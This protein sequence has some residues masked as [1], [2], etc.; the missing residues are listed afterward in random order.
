[1]KCINIRVLVFVISLAMSLA[2]SFDELED[3]SNYLKETSLLDQPLKKFPSDDDD[4]S[5]ISDHAWEES[6]RFEGDLILNER[7]RQLIV[8][9]IAEGLSRNGLKDSTKRWPNNEVIVYIQREHFTSDQV[10]A[11]VSGM[12][13]LSQ[14][15]CVKF[16]PYKKGDRD[17]VVVQGSRRGCFSQVGYQGGYQVLNLSGRHPVGR[18]CFRHGTV[19][20]EFLH[21][22]GFYHMQSSPDRDDYIDVIWENIVQPAR[23]NFRKYNLFSVSDFGVGYDYDSV[24]HYSRKAFSSNGGDTLVPKKS[25]AEIGQRI[26]LSE[27]DSAKLNKMYCD[28][29]SNNFEAADD[30]SHAVI[31]K[32]KTPKNKPFD[33]HGIG[34]H[35]GKTV[36]FKLPAADNYR[37]PEKPSNALFDYF[38]KEPQAVSPLLIKGFGVGQKITY[39]YKLPDG[40]HI[41]QHKIP[42]YRYPTLFNRTNNAVASI[43][44]QHNGKNNNENIKTSINN[45]GNGNKNKESIEDLDEKVINEPSPKDRDTGNGND[46]TIVYQPN[47]DYS[48]FYNPVNKYKIGTET[49]YYLNYSPKAQEH[50]EQGTKEIPDLKLTRQFIEKLREP[51]AM[52]Y[53]NHNNN[54]RENLY[55]NDLINKRKIIDKPILVTKEENTPVDHS[56]FGY[57]IPSTKLEEINKIYL[58]NP[59]YTSKKY[60]ENKNDFSSLYY[61]N[62]NTNKDAAPKNAQ[63]KTFGETVPSTITYKFK[64]NSPLIHGETPNVHTDLDNEERKK[65][66]EKYLTNK[67]IS[68]YKTDG[69][70][71]EQYSYEDFGPHDTTKITDYPQ[72]TSNEENSSKSYEV[73][74]K[75]SEQVELVTE[76]SNAYSKLHDEEIRL[77]KR[78]PTILEKYV[79]YDNYDIT[80]PYYVSDYYRNT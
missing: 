40:F 72:P 7:Q 31:K 29:D 6:G 48:K 18:G 10:Q 36:V 65:E 41:A 16:R 4:D 26:G 78:L 62:D 63:Y 21:T 69:N 70:S 24:L 12:E 30:V 17:A 11:I 56:S 2:M 19:V 61:P 71:D 32:K 76:K 79:N 51:K 39:T 8:Q 33:G 52:S 35:Q 67:P 9:D 28:A 77:E 80:A 14:A 59:E 49:N 42:M 25:G 34:Y 1:M 74:E 66:S 75:L 57:V 45:A 15:S 23:H 58:I 37:L 54:E 27:K 20:H 55:Q 3:F 60:L 53:R 64:Q 68:N 5:P 50:N 47:T 44:R 46:F 43:F 73:T 38:S 22:L 13:E